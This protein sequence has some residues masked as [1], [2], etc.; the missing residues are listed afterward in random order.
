M[1]KLQGIRLFVAVVD[2]GGFAGAARAMNVSPPV[3]TR[4]INELEENLGVRLL[5][6]STRLVRVTDAG[7]RYAEDCRRVLED[8]QLADEQVCGV[9]GSPQG[10]LNLTA[11][12]WFGASYMAPIVAE[13]LQAYPG[14]AVNCMFT[15]RITNLLEEG[16]D[17]ALRFANLADSSMQAVSVG[18]MNIVT[19]ASPSY[20]ER[21]G[22]PTHPRD[23]AGHEVVTSTVAPGAE[24][25]YRESGKD[26]AVRLKPRMTCS[27][28]E[29]VVSA[30]SAGFGLGQQM[31]Y[32]VAEPL[33]SG[34]LVTVLDEFAPAA[35]P[36]T[37]LHREGRFATTKVRAFLD[38]AIQ[39]LRA[40]PVLHV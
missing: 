35:L 11:P 12:G 9:H 30:V 6:R 15:D 32:K 38:L 36:V 2:Q 22:V 10:T 21:H 8:L 33:A 23:L 26:T 16:V 4:A 14:V 31:L 13:Y 37:L 3:V 27:N 1:D 40:L 18:R 7:A 19:V 29:A 39:R 17:V 24:F 25:R 34:A 28:N 5:N 20:L